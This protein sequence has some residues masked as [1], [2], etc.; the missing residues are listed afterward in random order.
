[1][2]RMEGKGCKAKGRRENGMGRERRSKMNGWKGNMDEEKWTGN[3][4]GT[5]VV[6]R[7]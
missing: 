1:M 7:G 3:V 6:E 4:K 5:E 2:E